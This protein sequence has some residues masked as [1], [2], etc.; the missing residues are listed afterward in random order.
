MLLKSLRIIRDDKII[1]FVVRDV[2]RELGY[3]KSTHPE[4]V[5][6]S[7]PNEWKMMRRI[8]TKGGA[9]LMWCISVNGLKYLCEHC[10]RSMSDSL[11]AEI[12]QVNAA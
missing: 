9:Q 5:I 2:M 11:A 4:R 8:L 7:V 3:A 6:E 12:S 1:W 10:C